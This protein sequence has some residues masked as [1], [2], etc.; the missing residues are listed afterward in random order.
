MKKIIAQIFLELLYLKKIKIMVHV[1]EL[2]V[3]AMVTFVLTTVTSLVGVK[4]TRAR[5]IFV[6]LAHQRTYCNPLY[7]R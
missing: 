4:M 6:R 7:F 2:F 5:L 1:M 3:V